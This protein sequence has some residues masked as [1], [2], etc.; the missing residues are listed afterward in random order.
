MTFEQFKLQAREHALKEF[1][2][3]KFMQPQL[4]AM[5]EQH[6]VAFEI[7]AFY[8][9]PEVKEATIRVIKEMI[10]DRKYSAVCFAIESFSLEL[11]EGH[12]DLTKIQS[13]EMRVRSH[14][15]RKD[16]INITYATPTSEDMEVILVDADN[17]LILNDTNPEF[18]AI[19]GLLTNLYEIYNKRT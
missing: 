7:S 15:A 12:P 8:F 17:R 4:T 14:P 13:G 9:N 3:N 5:T 19:S 18:K 2:L 11:P 10:A 16:V 6:M 1:K